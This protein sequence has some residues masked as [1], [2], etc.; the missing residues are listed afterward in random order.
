MTRVAKFSCSKAK[1]PFG[2]SNPK[3]LIDKN[4]GIRKT[5]LTGYAEGLYLVVLRKNGKVIE[6][7]KLILTQ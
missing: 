7:T 2:V 3:G 4:Q 6:Q 5:D 1:K